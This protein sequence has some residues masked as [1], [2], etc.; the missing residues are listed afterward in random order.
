MKIPLTDKIKK[1]IGPTLT[2]QEPYNSVKILEKLRHSLVHFRPE[3]EIITIEEEGVLKRTES[4]TPLDNDL[5]IRYCIPENSDIAISAFRPI[6]V[7]GTKWASDSVFLIAHQIEKVA[8][9]QGNKGLFQI[10]TLAKCRLV[11]YQIR[12]KYFKEKPEIVQELML[13]PK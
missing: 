10:Y 8:Y 6:T 5:K 2:G 3:A 13:I 4:K 11:T 7:E 1:I 9:D 12:S